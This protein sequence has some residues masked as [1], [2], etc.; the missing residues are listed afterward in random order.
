MLTQAQAKE[1]QAGLNKLGY[2]AGNVDGVIGRGTRGALQKFQKER[3][4]V[5]DGF[6]TQDMLIKV[7]AAAA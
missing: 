7:A 6:P 3:G 5:A 4:L 1:M 2:S